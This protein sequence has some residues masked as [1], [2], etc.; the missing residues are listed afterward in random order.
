MSSSAVVI[1]LISAI[2]EQIY[3]ILLVCAYIASL[4]YAVLDTLA[5]PI[6]SDHF[7]FGVKEEYYAVLGI[8]AGLFISSWLL[9][10]AAR[11]YLQCTIMYCYMHSHAFI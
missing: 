4:E 8:S 6:L 5:N 1:P 11:I 9:Y 3:T 2:H 10:V 7:G